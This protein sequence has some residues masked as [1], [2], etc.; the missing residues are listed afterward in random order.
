M[1]FKTVIF[2]LSPTHDTHKFHFQLRDTFFHWLSPF[3]EFFFETNPYSKDPFLILGNTR[4]HS[5]FYVG[6]LCSLKST[7]KQH[8]YNS[9][10]K[11]FIS[12]SVMQE[13]QKQVISRKI[14]S[15]FSPINKNFTYSAPH[16][17]YL[18][19]HTI[20]KFRSQQKLCL[21]WVRLPING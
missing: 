3:S 18:H 10:S 15:T 14:Y 6:I 13:L 16:N 20:G 7:T 5:R 9:F 17:N 2:F 21:L 8:R 19:P 11:S 4:F 12:F 1:N